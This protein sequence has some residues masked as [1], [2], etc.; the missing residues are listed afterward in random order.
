M[1]PLP[2]APLP[3]PVA[4]LGAEGEGALVLDYLR[5]LAAHR[6][7]RRAV[8]LRLSLLRPEHRRAR[9]V[10]A[11]SALFA[12]L[13]DAGTGQLFVLP[14]SDML[15]IYR[16]E[17]QSEVNSA[18]ARAGFL[19]SDDSLFADD[20]SAARFA[21]WY[22][23]ATDYER[24]LAVVTG[25]TRSD[26]ERGAAEEHPHGSERHGAA[27]TPE[28]LAKLEAALARTDLS[29]LVRRQTVC[30]VSTAFTPEPLFTE[31]Y[32]SIADLSDVVAPDKDLAANP[33]LFRRLTRTLDRR[34]LAL[35]G[36]PDGRLGSAVGVSINL[37]V[38]TLLSDAFQSFTESLYAPP[39]RSLI[40]ELQAMDVFAD[41][42]AFLLARTAVRGRG[43]RL[44]L[45]GLHW[46]DADLIDADSLG[47]EFAKII[48]DAELLDGGAAEGRLAA[49]VERAG[50]SRLVL[51]HVDRREAIELGQA[52]GITLF[53]GRCIDR[54]LAEDRRRRQQLRLKRTGRALP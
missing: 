17:A 32:V 7:G 46:R 38:S 10:R 35:L 9:H 43:Y 13:V 26:T 44:A 3:R 4:R 2:P 1:I 40:I 39:A 48:A 27:L 25:L 33:R 14:G 45:D 37:N 16:E 52:L 51:C 24:L 8:R 20:G 42:D 6:Q 11:A 31:L 21:E 5:A 29:N 41:L 22:D 53:Q 36:G 30:A 15:F 23:V 12:P 54:L 34:V 18:V 50:P 49:L 28:V 19:F 47:F